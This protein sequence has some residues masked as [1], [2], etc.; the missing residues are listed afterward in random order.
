MFFIIFL[1]LILT[2]Y[3]IVSTLEENTKMGYYVAVIA[4]LLL[5]IVLGILL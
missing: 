2:S 4:F 1:I 3:V 5:Y